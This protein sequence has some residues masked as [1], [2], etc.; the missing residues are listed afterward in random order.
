MLHVFN[1]GNRQPEVANVID[2]F[3]Q[4]KLTFYFFVRDFASM[5]VSRVFNKTIAMIG[6]QPGFL[7]LKFQPIQGLVDTPVFTNIPS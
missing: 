1:I 7:R 4:I 5:R 3:E 6:I 2:P